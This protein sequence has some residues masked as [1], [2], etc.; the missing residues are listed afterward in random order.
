MCESTNPATG[1]AIALGLLLLTNTTLAAQII[2]VDADA[3][4]ANDGSSWTNAY[5]YLQDALTDAGSA[6]KPAEIR[7]A[8]GIYRPDR[9][10]AEPNGTSNRGATF[11]LIN[12]VTLKGGY[13][14]IFETDPNERNIKKYET[15]LSGDL[16]GND[17]DVND[18]CDLPAEPTRAENTYHVVTSSDTDETSVLDG[19]TITGG[20]A[21]GPDLRDR[22]G[23]GIFNCLDSNP[24][25]TNCT[26]SGNKAYFGG[27]MCNWFRSG[28]PKLTN[29]T[30]SG[31]SASAGGGGMY[32][33]SSN[34]LELTNCIFRGNWAIR[35]GGMYNYRSSPKLTN[36][37]FC[38][39]SANS[40]GGVLNHN[41]KPDMLSCVFSGNKA[42]IGGGMFNN[43]LGDPVLGNCTFSGN[44][45]KEGGGIYNTHSAVIINNCTFAGNA[46]PQGCAV[47][48]DSYQM[49]YPSVVE[50]SNCILRDSGAEI[51]N[52]D[53]SSIAINYSDVQDEQM[54]LY[55]PREGLV[56]GNGN[57]DVDPCFAEPGYW[58]P[59]GTPDDPNDD[60]WVDGD[61][62]L[63]SQAGRWDPNSQSWV[64]D[65]VT[66]PCI[67]AGDPN[68]P[69][70]HE[71][72]PNGGIINMG[73]YGGATEASK[74]Y[75]GEPICETI[76]AGDINGDCKV[77]FN[78]LILV[79]AHWLEDN[80]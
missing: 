69:V 8:Q 58:D 63:K 53:G 2:Y 42:Y 31:N 45:A 76:T 55:D 64:Q 62:H 22:C 72:F 51:W 40:G 1:L 27:G 20:Y 47:A 15:I 30:F 59:N 14:G 25:L 37:T 70:G 3:T 78:D 5:K 56:W 4:G 43:V 16:A 57:I 67:D 41:S 24:T 33:R 6:D 66:S 36:C 10:A 74:S 39:N 34:G 54:S 38:A 26:F 46:A 9:N 48:C 21:D 32:N 65:D 44:S 35:G 68:S 80:R 60:S 11:Q 73:A 50:I 28:S 79:V 17:V 71:P 49:W 18:P 7:V 75:F 19:F 13:A 23:G 29:C 61:Y 12:G 52:N 77:D